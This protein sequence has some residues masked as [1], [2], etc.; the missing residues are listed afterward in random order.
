MLT[1]RW[2]QQDIVLLCC[3]PPL[4]AMNASAPR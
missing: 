4:A 1:A 3:P 2:R